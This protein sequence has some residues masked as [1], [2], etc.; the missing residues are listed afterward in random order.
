MNCEEYLHLMC[1]H[2]DGCN[3]EME[4]KRLQQHLEHC[5]DC[6]AL[7]AQ[8]QENERL[9]GESIAEPPA[10]LSARIM[11]AVRKEPK[12]K[13]SRKRFFTS[14]ATAGL[15]TAA[16]L[17]LVFFGGNG[18]PQLVTEDAA[19]VAMDNAPGDIGD[20]EAME[21]ATEAVLDFSDSAVNEGTTPRAEST[22][23]APDTEKT[24]ED[25][26]SAP[27]QEVPQATADETWVAGDMKLYTMDANSAYGATSPS[28]TPAAGLSGIYGIRAADGEL[29]EIP[30]LIIYG[31]TPEDFPILSIV[32][33]LPSHIPYAQATNIAADGSFY[34]RF[35][36]IIP[37]ELGLLPGFPNEP[38]YNLCRYS[39]SYE[40]FTRLQDAAIGSYETAV[41]FPREIDKKGDCLIILIY[42]EEKK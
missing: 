25:R 36:S 9:L 19:M 5:E 22:T 26:N 6:R 4:E 20:S 41:Y 35:F 10:D 23:A 2:M 12:K 29:Q 17:A 16:L 13:P 14:I 18:L 40:G 7:L 28:S 37:S 38:E 8:L 30:T 21:N 33:P 3:S 27:S 1:G 32:S 24:C 11:E 39:V 15:A 42:A 34:Q 31:A